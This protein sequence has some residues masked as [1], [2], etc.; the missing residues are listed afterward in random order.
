MSE[1]Q[2]WSPGWGINEESDPEPACFECV[3]GPFILHADHIKIIE[4][5]KALLTDG[6]SRYCGWYD[7]GDPSVNGSHMAYD[8]VSVMR[9][10]LKKLGGT[11]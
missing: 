6:C 3:D 7:N 1:I 11:G 4:S 10:V 2:R 8:L 5:V 9:Q